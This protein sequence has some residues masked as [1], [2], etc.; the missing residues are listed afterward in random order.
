M[1][2]RHALVLL[3]ALSLRALPA[4]IRGGGELDLSEAIKSGDNPAEILQ[5]SLK[6]WRH[7][8]VPAGLVVTL[9][10][11]IDVPADTLIEGPGTIHLTDRAATLR[12]AERVTVRDLT[13]T[14]EPAFA[15]GSAI[16]MATAEVGQVRRMDATVS[17]CRFEKMH[18]HALYA[19]EVSH[20][21][22]AANRWE[23]HSDDSKFYNPTYLHA[24]THFA[25]RDNTILHG[26]QGIQFRGG[27]YNTVTGN[28]LVNC[29]Q[30]I[31]CY[32]LGSHPSHWPGTLFAHNVIANNVIRRAREEGIA[33]DNSMGE[34]PAVKAAQ[35]QVRAVATVKT[36]A[37]GD[38]NRFRLT[39]AEPA[40]PGR[41]YAAGWADGYFVGVLTGKAA[42]LLLEV[43]ASGA[44]DGAAW[45]DLPRVGEKLAG[46]LAAGDRVWI[47]AGCF[48]NTITGNVVDNSGEVSGHGNA[49]CIGLW[50]AAWCNTITA[51]VCTTRQYGI[52]LGCVGL[53]RPDSP[54][55]PSAGNI[56]SHNIVSATWRGAKATTETRSVGGIGFVWIGDGP[57]LGGRLFLGN[58]ISHNTLTWGADRPIRLGRDCGTHVAFNRIAGG[59]AIDMDHTTDAVLEGNLDA[60]GQSFTATSRT[61]PCTFRHVGEQPK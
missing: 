36:T 39:L 38:A 34:T 25:I 60:T 16:T 13:F 11:A 46:Q 24:V 59:G 8:R 19:A 1:K 3:T 33:Y 10:R 23:N 22:F 58:T 42:G 53:A 27:R 29:L 50:G 6:T 41:A 5:R 51:N 55:G 40:N 26:N 9:D 31:T 56:I 28:T 2:T 35:N 7:V 47:A 61:G 12:L 15:H 44:D 30:G 14:C 17:G 4:E 49:T 32:T 54:Q 37:A 52:T 43:V 48:Y 57:L 20:V 45:I 21:I 18:G